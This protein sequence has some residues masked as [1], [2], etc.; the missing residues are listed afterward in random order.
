MAS[1]L[2]PTHKE[3]G[4]SLIEAM[5]SLIVMS[6]GMLGI[7]ALYGQGL[8]AGS[9]ALYRTQAVTLVADMADRIREN[10]IAGV[11]YNNAPANHACDP[12][13][14]AN[15]TP[16]EM[17]E[18]DVFNWTA[19]VAALLP[20]G[21]GSVRFAAGTPPSYTIQVQWEETGLAAPATYQVVIRVPNI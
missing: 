17:A 6:V 3:T 4:F 15:C 20:S 12:G 8:R 1:M 19:Q 10:R 9:S 2:R 11:F 18:H 5:V 13:G 21:V 14:G 16:T 7:A